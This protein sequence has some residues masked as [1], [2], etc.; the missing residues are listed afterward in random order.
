M[1]KKTKKKM[2]IQNNFNFEKLTEEKYQVKFEKQ[3]KKFFFTNM[4][5]LY[6]WM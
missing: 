5:Y 1:R 6:C 4:L 2:K 3:N